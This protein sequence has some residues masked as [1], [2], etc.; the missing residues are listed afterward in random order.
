MNIAIELKDFVHY[1]KARGERENELLSFPLD[2]FF[3]SQRRRRRRR[4]LFSFAR[5]SDTTSTTSNPVPRDQAELRAVLEKDV[6]GRLRGV[7]SHAVVSDYRGGGRG[8]LELRG[9]IVFFFWGGGGGASFFRKEV[10]K[11]E[12]R[13]E[14][15]HFH[16]F[17]PPRRHT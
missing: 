15:N 10:E 2:F 8:D 16:V 12:K 6:P 14:I 9:R 1:T 13:T 17:L 3:S 11:K 5:F 7:D 4:L